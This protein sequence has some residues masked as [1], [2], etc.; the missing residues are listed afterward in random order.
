MPTTNKRLQQSITVTANLKQDKRDAVDG[1]HSGAVVVQV[2][3]LVA[4]APGSG[5]AIVIE[6]AAVLEENQFEPLS[7]QQISLEVAGPTSVAL[8][9]HSRHLRWTTISMGGQTSTFTIDLAMRD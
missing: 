6:H 3:C 8:T 4:A 2:N 7:A 5:A 1:L 9:T